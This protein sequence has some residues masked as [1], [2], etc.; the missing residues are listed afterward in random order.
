MVMHEAMHRLL[1][2]DIPEN[3]TPASIR[4]ILAYLTRFRGQAVQHCLTCRNSILLELGE[5]CNDIV[6]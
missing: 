2:W 5:E 4:G 3:T 1:P 6:W